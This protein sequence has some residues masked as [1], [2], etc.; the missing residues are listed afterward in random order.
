MK[1]WEESSRPYRI[2]VSR[3]RTCIIFASDNG[4]FYKATN[5][6]PLRANKG[7]YYEGGIRVPLIIDWPGTIENGCVIDQPVI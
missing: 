4:G 7:A 2:L 6:A 5:N 3:D 1:V